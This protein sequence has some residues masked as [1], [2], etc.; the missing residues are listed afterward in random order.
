MK[1]I[2]PELPVKEKGRDVIKT[3][4]HRYP[5]LTI[6]PAPGKSKSEEYKNIAL[7]GKLPKEYENPFTGTQEDR[8][9]CI[10]TPVGDVEVLYLADRGDFETCVRALAYK[11]EREEI[12]ASMGAIHI[13]GV[14]NWAKIQARKRA[15][16]EAGNSDWSAEFRRFTADPANYKD[17]VLLVS[18]GAYSALPAAKAG[19]GE[20]EWLGYSLIIRI[21]HEL[22]HLIC[23]KR[24]PEKK[25]AV[26]DEIVADCMGIYKA[27][28]FYD[29]RLAEKLLGVEGERYRKGARLENYVADRSELRHC[30]DRARQMI[31]RLSVL[32]GDCDKE[33]YWELLFRIEENR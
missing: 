10:P 11:C 27:L 19:F 9:F 21:Y 33:A 16:L 6:S 29:T 31:Q 13:G 23:R 7:R 22:T 17:T 8:V 30:R 5:Q 4:I 32:A 24:Y 14:N 20:E 18:K 25:E 1:A 3:Y 15:Y 26:W 2:P 28:G 12:P